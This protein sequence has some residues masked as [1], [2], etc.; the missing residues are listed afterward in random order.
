M[1]GNHGYDG[2]L[3]PAQGVGPGGKQILEGYR[4]DAVNGFAPEKPRFNPLNTDRP[5]SSLHVDLKD[6]IQV[7]L[8]TETALTD[9]KEW[10]ILSQEEVD[11]LKKQIQSLTVRI[12]QARANLAIQTKYR[13]AAI[14]MS[15][16]YTAGK[17]GNRA[18]VDPNA[19][20]TA[21][22]RMESERVCEELATELFNLEKE[23][24]AP[25][26]RLLQHTAAILQLTHKASS[27]KKP[28]PAM[29]NG[30]PQSP[31]SLYT[32]TNGRNSMQFPNDDLDRALY[33]PLD[34]P[35]GFGRPPKSDI[36]IPPRS[37]VRERSNQLRDEV[38]TLKK[39]NAGQMDIITNTERTLEDLNNRLREL[40]IQIDP[41]KNADYGPAP[42]G[43]IEP[44]ELL[45]SQLDYLVQG[46][47]SIQQDSQGQQNL[48]ADNIASL[49][50]AE[51]RLNALNR[52]I[53]DTILTT[54]GDHPA[55]PEPTG[56][57]LEDHFEWVD[58]SL[59]VLQTQLARSAA[60]SDEA[61]QTEQIETVLSGLWNMIQAGYADINRQREARRQVRLGQGLEDDDDDDVSADESFDY[62]EPYS[63]E[64]F[65]AKVQWLFRQSTSLKEQKS[66]LKRQ[67][68]QQRSLNNKSDSEKDQELRNKVEELNRTK[69]LLAF[70]EE[71]TQQAKA[72][73]AEAQQKLSQALA[74]LDTMQVTQAANETA[75]T[76]AVQDQLRDQ[77]RERNAKLASFEADSRAL[78]DKLEIVEA[79][80]GTMTE[81]LREADDA[82]QATQEEK[83]KL[84]EQIKVKDEELEQVNVSMIELKTELTIAKAELEGAYGSR[85]ERAAEVAA[86]TK[87]KEMQ[88]MVQQTEKLKKEL[89]STLKEFEDLTKEMLQSEKEK[90]DLE[91]RLDQAVST[92]S[93]LESDI[94]TLRER[95]NTE[96][97]RLKEQLEAEKFKAGPNAAGTGPRA[98]ASM[99][100]EQ[101]RTMMK[102]ERRKF[103][104]EIKEEHNRRRK[105]EEEIRALKKAA[106]PG[107]S[108]LS[109]RS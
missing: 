50:Q 49:R 98:G 10:E 3:S 9:S 64:A 27:K 30:I 70:C 109:P 16:L 78:Q 85:S 45:N 61:Q 14:S 55:P 69:N 95:Y 82:K 7:H 86:M 87:R 31:E 67:I 81:Q 53:H 33:F 40:V 1:N 72:E 94:A 79:Q 18:T 107:K 47:E 13:D 41:T 75:A 25:Q 59:S 46:L 105:L 88:E 56:S 23:A 102:E 26:R 80:L 93:T 38:E 24:L 103:Q 29:L 11:D 71:S 104:E 84:E 63:L 42:S 99:L 48:L 39:Q 83:W 21:M 58:L 52:Q 54:D 35:E 96:V 106:G 43:N 76:S 32:Y 37:P 74:D 2:L 73:A 66:V 91:S 92:R 15:K 28:S 17:I 65:T 51:E 8:L 108:S 97:N 89:E 62:E 6:P 100:S 44:G 77:L 19:Q 5:Q 90:V 34:E 57:G 60:S 20:E 4:N 68:K 36:P 12:E 101:F 22:E